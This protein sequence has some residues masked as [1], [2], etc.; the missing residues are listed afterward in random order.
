MKQ[1]LHF[2]HGPYAGQ[3]VEVDEDEA[4][5]QA[6]LDTGF[7]SEAEPEPEPLPD[8]EPEAPKK[9]VAPKKK[10]AKKAPAKKRVKKQIETPE[11]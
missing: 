8:P 4:A 5:I 11:G 9:P 6:L 10:A 2:H 3:V 1:R 7:C